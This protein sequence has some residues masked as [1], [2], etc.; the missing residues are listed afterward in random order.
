MSRV[1]NAIV[2]DAPQRSEKWFAARL[3]NV[4]GSKG[5]EAIRSVEGID[6]KHAALRTILNMRAISAQFKLT[7]DYESFM[8]KSGYELYKD[9]ELELPDNEKRIQYKR[10]R[11][12]ERLTGLS[13]D[14][15][16]YIS[17]AMIW[18]QTN[19]RLALAKYQMVTGNKVDEAFFLLHPELRCG[20]SSDGNVTDKVTGELGVL[21]IKCLESHNHLYKIMQT[22]DV[23]ED[24][25]VQIQMEMWLANVDYCDFVGYDSRLPGKLDIFV[26]RVKRDDWFI[27]EVLEPEIR[28]FLDEVDKEERY[29]RMLARKGFEFNLDEYRGVANA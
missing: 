21:E 3:G 24:Y 10:T 12:V 17:K 27:D 20:V 6:A 2:I 19:E 7:P 1:T 11:V 4:T 23:P 14:Q 5:K 13:A 26:K 22:Q 29:F 18:G 16:Q 8:S 28:I 15:D 25:L 9:A